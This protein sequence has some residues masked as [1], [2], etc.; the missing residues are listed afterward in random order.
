MGR[1]KENLILFRLAPKTNKLH[2][3]H[4]R[5]LLQTSCKLKLVF[6]TAPNFPMAWVSCSRRSKSKHLNRKRRKNRGHCRKKRMIIQSLRVACLTWD[7]AC[8]CSNVRKKKSR[9][10]VWVAKLS[11]R[12]LPRC[13]SSVK[14][15]RKICWRW[16]R[17]LRHYIKETQNQSDIVRKDKLKSI[18]K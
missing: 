16:L 15:D 3:N 9:S 6:P 4:Q 17:M 11:S 1:C 14:Q 10:I 5:L 7:R 8:R 12:D 2:P 18:V 13:F